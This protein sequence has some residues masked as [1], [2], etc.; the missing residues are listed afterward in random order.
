VF[1]TRGRT[2]KNKRKIICF[3]LKGIVCSQIFVV[4]KSWIAIWK[5][6]KFKQTKR[7]RKNILR[8]KM[9]LMCFLSIDHESLILILKIYPPEGINFRWNMIENVF[10]LIFSNLFFFF[11][12]VGNPLAKY[13]LDLQITITQQQIHSFARTY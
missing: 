12:F 5:D 3:Q 7:K 4:V 6:R 2:R 10:I 8:N 9:I 13:H 11:N 1:N